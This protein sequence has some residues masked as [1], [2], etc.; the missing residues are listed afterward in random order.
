M[1]FFLLAALLAMAPLSAV[2]Q[3]GVHINAAYARVAAP[4][5][6][7]GAVFMTIVNDATTDDRLIA[8]TSDVAEK[9]ELHTHAMT[10]DGVMQMLAVPEGFVIPAAGSHAL[11][12]GGDHVM[13][14]GRT[15]PLAAGDTFS[16][17]LAF[18]RA[19]KVVV[20]VQVNND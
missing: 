15:R 5:A 8:V 16:L 4:T 18:E 11:E 13:L 2:A 10:A 6:Q 14:L 7:A 3:D 1:R 9:V 12:R 17:T 20:I 19:G